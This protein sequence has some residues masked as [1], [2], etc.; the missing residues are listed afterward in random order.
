[1]DS[2]KRWWIEERMKKSAEK[3][4]A[5]DFEALYVQTKEEA[6]KEI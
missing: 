2:N 6:I 4:K 3:L 5:H 1:M